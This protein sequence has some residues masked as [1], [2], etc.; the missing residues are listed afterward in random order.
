[1]YIAKERRPLALLILLA[2][3]LG[4][5]L[6]S[7]AFNL[8]RHDAQHVNVPLHSAFEAFGGMAAI[9]MAIFFL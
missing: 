5:I 3:T 4:S 8:H 7:I 9:A 6:T 2:L 1:M